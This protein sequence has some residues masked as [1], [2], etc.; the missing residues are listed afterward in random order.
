LSIVNHC[1]CCESSSKLA[2]YCLCY[3]I[4]IV[5]D[6][7][8]AHIVGMCEGGMKGTYIVGIVGVTTRT[9]PTIIKQFKEGGTNK[10]NTRTKRPKKL[11][12][13]DLCRV[14]LFSRTHR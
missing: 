2:S 11:G 9:E 1:F 14:L 5:S 4:I 7:I 8:C 3:K 6:E 13:R 10:E 12:E